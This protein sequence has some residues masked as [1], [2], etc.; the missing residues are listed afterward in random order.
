MAVLVIAH[1]GFSA[2]HVENSLEAFEAAIAAGADAIETDVRLSRDGVPV[3]SHDPDLKRLRGRSESV[4]DLD[5]AELER[6][7]V[8]TLST[9]LMAAR[10][11]IKVMLDLKLSTEADL[12]AT[13][14]VVH[15]LGIGADVF[16]GVRA[17]AL[18]PIARHLCPEA[19]VLGLPRQ[20]AELPAFYAAGGT[21]GR[22]W[23]AEATRAGIAVA[24]SGGHTVWVT[25][26]GRGGGGTGDIGAAGLKRL[27]ADGA[28]GVIVNDPALA[29]A[30]R[31]E[32][33]G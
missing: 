5:A 4:A 20:P 25:A 23:E 10:G 6:E 3:C 19:T 14:G 28:D 11:R 16:V 8:L 22:L 33:L 2:A 21:I 18:V 17:V 9:V 12:E 7:G 27:Y 15:A 24:K 13:L 1:R 30:V 29:L 26:G 32:A 31:A